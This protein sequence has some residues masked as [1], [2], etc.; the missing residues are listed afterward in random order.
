MTQSI[1]QAQETLESIVDQFSTSTVI[2][3]LSEIANAKADH[4]RVTNWQ[5]EAL[6]KQWER[7]ARVLDKSYVHNKVDRGL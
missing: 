3:M 7:L 1:T 2:S 5:D 6:A 4:I